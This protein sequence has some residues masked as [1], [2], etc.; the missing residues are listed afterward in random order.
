MSKT[1]SNRHDKDNDNSRRRSTYWLVTCLVI[2]V[3]IS[4]LDA[5]QLLNLDLQG[6]RHIMGNLKTLV[7][8]YDHIDLDDETGTAVV[9]AD[10]VD[11][12]D[13]GGVRGRCARKRQSA[14]IRTH[15]QAQC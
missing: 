7:A 6:F 3:D 4:P 8:V 15:V 12:L 5:R 9:C 11:L 2:D 1:H 13:V 14:Y 10:C